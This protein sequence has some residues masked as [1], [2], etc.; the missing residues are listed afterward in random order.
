MKKQIFIVK[1]FCDTCKSVFE[2]LE[3]ESFNVLML[4]L[5]TPLHLPIHFHASA[6]ILML[7]SG[8]VVTPRVSL[9]LNKS[10]KDPFLITPNSS[11]AIQSVLAFLSKLC[12]KELNTTTQS[13]Y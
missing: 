10:I 7:F 12:H 2:A 11:L 1:S 13:I 4:Q 3:A 6:L 5:N 9:L 8:T